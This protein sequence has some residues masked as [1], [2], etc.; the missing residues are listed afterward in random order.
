[1]NQRLHM[2]SYKSYFDIYSTWIRQKV[3][4]HTIHLGSDI[5]SMDMGFILNQLKMN[6]G[7]FSPKLEVKLL[8]CIFVICKIKLQDPGVCIK[9]ECL[10]VFNTVNRQ[11]L[12]KNTMSSAKD[13]PKQNTNIK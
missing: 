13:T 11:T 7:I 4:R 6:L 12:R 1:M 8:S 3:M 5:I 9:M 2:S 10:P